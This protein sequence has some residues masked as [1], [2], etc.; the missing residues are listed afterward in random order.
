[1]SVGT[2]LNTR[3][4]VVIANS[5]TPTGIQDLTETTASTITNSATVPIRFSPFQ[6]GGMNIVYDSLATEDSGRGLDGYNHITWII[7][8]ARK[9]ELILPPCTAAFS[10]QVLN[11]VLGK[12]FYI[13]YWDIATNQEKA[14]YAYCSNGRGS[15]YSGVLRNNGLYTGVSFNAIEVKGE[16]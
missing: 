10:A 12:H 6:N 4:E 7:S 16:T 2:Y 9:V 5:A 3:G 1:M 11:R 8:R 15:Q 13:I 14:I